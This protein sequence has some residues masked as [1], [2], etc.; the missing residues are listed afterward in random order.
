MEAL[1]TIFPTKDVKDLEKTA[2]I[3]ITID[4]AIDAVLLENKQK[5]REKCTTKF[6]PL[7]NLKGSSDICFENLK[8]FICH[9]RTVLV[10]EEVYV[11]RVNRDEIWRTSLAFYKKC[12]SN[13]QNLH[14]SFEVSIYIFD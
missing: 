10:N 7:K 3:S 1:H 11:L 4:D 6:D 2:D 14:K 5:E 9:I 12:L 8:M 13:V